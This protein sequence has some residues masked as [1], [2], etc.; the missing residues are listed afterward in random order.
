MATKKQAAEV[1][2]VSTKEILRMIERG[3]LKAKKKTA[4]VFSDWDID[5]SSVKKAGTVEAKVKAVLSEV[6]TP[7]EAEADSEELT[8]TTQPPVAAEE[9]D[10]PVAEERDSPAEVSNEEVQ[11]QQ[12]IDE[13]PPERHVNPAL[14]RRRLFLLRRRQQ[15]EAEE[16]K[17]KESASNGKR[18]DRGRTQGHEGDGGRPKGDNQA[19][20]KEGGSPKEPTWWF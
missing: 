14:E 18:T 13:K 2:G 1:L 11:E 8:E 7:P 4:S 6:V 15:R 10:S 3:E 19:P 9:R 17:R 20:P 12:V 5:L 16:S